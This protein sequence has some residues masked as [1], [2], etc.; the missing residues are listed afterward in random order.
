MTEKRGRKRDARRDCPNNV[1]ACGALSAA[2]GEPSLAGQTG[3]LAGDG[4]ERSASQSPP[5]P[6][7]T[8]AR[9]Y[10]SEPEGDGISAAG[11]LH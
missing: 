11:P 2:L 7:C 6:A 10:R 8:P 3:K 1:A 4:S 5:R 9:V